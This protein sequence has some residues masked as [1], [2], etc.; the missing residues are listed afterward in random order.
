MHAKSKTFRG[1]TG[2]QTPPEALLFIRRSVI[3]RL[4][5]RD[6]DPQENQR[7]GLMGCFARNDESESFQPTLGAVR[8]KVIVVR[9]LL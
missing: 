4:L 5:G 7:L 3:A 1:S 8:P 6:D 2:L 9:E